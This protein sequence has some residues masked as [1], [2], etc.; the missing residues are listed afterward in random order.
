MK[1]VAHAR[2]YFWLLFG[3]PFPP[4]A[5]EHL[6]VKEF[7]GLG[8]SRADASCTWRSLETTSGCMDLQALAHLPL[9]SLNQVRHAACMMTC[10]CSLYA[11][12]LSTV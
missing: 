7:G 11:C 8:E 6:K 9:H 12:P 4:A 5:L 2:I 1:Q 3:P 10:L